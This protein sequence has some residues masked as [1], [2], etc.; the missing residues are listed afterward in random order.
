M[1]QAFDMVPFAY[2]FFRRDHQSIETMHEAKS[3]RNTHAEHPFKN[4]F[5]GFQCRRE[6]EMVMNV[7]LTYIARSATSQ[8]SKNVVFHDHPCF[9]CGTR[10]VRDSAA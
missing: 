3:S 7:K 9:P 1:S 5:R 10:Q 6:R 8:K 4:I 2:N